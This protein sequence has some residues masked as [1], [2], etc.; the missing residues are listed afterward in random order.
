MV[1]QAATI[2]GRLDVVQKHTRYQWLLGY[3][4]IYLHHLLLQIFYLHIYTYLYVYVYIYMSFYILY[5]SCMMH[6]S[7]LYA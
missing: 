1:G 3:I 2:D 5:L 4:L 6:V 7:V